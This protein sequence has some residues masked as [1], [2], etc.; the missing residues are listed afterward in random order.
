[1][2][3]EERSAVSTSYPSDSQGSAGQRDLLLWPGVVVLAYTLLVGVGVIGDGFK[4]ISGGAD[5]A[6]QIFAF[7][8][9]PILGVILGTLATAL[10]QSSSTVTSVIV[11]LVAGGMPVSLAVPMI[12]GANM[13]TTITNT[14]VSLGNIKEGPAFSRSFGA[15]TVHDFFNLYSIILLLP[16][17]MLFHPLE[18]IAGA[19][20]NLFVGGESA[21]VASMNVLGKVTKP[22]VNWIGGVFKSLPDTLGAPLLI[23]VGIT[24]VFFSVLYL[25]KMLRRLMTG[26]AKGV[27]NA[28]FD[29]GAIIAIIAGS[30]ITIMVQSSSTTTSLV[31]PLVGAGVLTIMQIY[32]FTLGSN[33]GTTV[34]ALLAATAVTGGYKI[35]ALQ[36]AFVHFLYNFLAV[37]IF[38]ANPRLWQLPVR[39]AQW[40]G[41]M[42]EKSR[43]YALGYIV[44]VF[45]VLPAGVLGVQAILS[46]K[47]PAVIA[48]EADETKLEAV[49]EEIQKTEFA[50]E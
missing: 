15:A 49:E 12:M 31:V 48:A 40:L 42:A 41:N 13:G 28:A 39:S 1:M 23:I 17:E 10:V 30:I 7:A 25:G 20:A 6:E 19:L 32:P 29:H 4:L 9:N 34:T 14:I 33:I 43:L 46:D 24:L 26:K 3:K 35:F 38:A 36:I 37:A 8:T 50:I 11:A 44:V 27:L 22:S 21:S 18:R 45:F 2:A 47:V 16:I 5:G